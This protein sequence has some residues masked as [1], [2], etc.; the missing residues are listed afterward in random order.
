V[1]VPVIDLDLTMAESEP[2]LS[3]QTIQALTDDLGRIFGSAP[4]GTWLRIH[5]LSRSAY[6]ENLIDL[7]ADV[8]PV[9]VRVLKADLPDLA[10]R[11]AEA[12]AIAACV[13]RLINRPLENTHILFEPAA[14]GRIAFGGDLLE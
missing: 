13:S 2:V 1:A 7:P 4:G 8:Q 10:A 6:A 3:A 11:K 14:R 9:F 12:S 5:Y